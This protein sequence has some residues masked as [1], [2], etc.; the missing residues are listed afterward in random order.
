MK[1]AR[2]AS[3]LALLT[4]GCSP[5]PATAADSTGGAFTLSGLASSICR[6]GSAEGAAKRLAGVGAPA[7]RCGSATNG[8]LAP[9]IDA[10][11]KSDCSVGGGSTVAVCQYD[12]AQPG[13][14]KWVPAIGSG[15]GDQIRVNGA[16][17]TDPTLNDSAQIA[18]SASSNTITAAIAADS[19]ALGTHTSGAFVGGATSGGGLALTGSEP[20]TLGLL[21]CSSGQVLKHNGSAWACSADSGGDSF[22][23]FAASSGTNP[24]A[25]GSADTLQILA[26]TGVTV[27]GDAAADSL[28]IASTLGTTV[29]PTEMAASDFGPFSCNGTTCSIDAAAV[30]D[31]AVASGVDAAKLANGTVSNAEF[32]RLD[33][34]SSAIQS[35]LDAKVPLAGGT[36]S[37]QLNMGSQKITGL[38]PGSAAT[39]AVRYDQ[40]IDG[41]SVVMRDGSQAFTAAQSMGGNRITSLGSGTALTD[42]AS[43]REAA[44]CVGNAACVRVADDNG[45]AD[46][47]AELQAA[48]NALLWPSGT[49]TTAT[50]VVL[51]APP[52]RTY[53]ISSRI[54]ICGDT[55]PP[56]G[57]TAPDCTGTQQLPR[58]R[59]AG[60][61]SSAVLKCEL[62]ALSNVVQNMTPCIQIGD[63][64]ADTSF[65]NKVPLAFDTPLAIEMATTSDFANTLMGIWC[66]GC[67]ED[68]KVRVPDTK[69]SSFPGP[70]A[71]VAGGGLRTTL[72]VEKNSGS[73]ATVIFDG[74]QQGS[75]ASVRGSIYGLFIGSTVSTALATWGPADGCDYNG[76]TLSCADFHLLPET[77]VA[78]TSFS[79]EVADTEGAVIEGVMKGGTGTS[80]PTIDVRTG[81]GANSIRSLAIRATCILNAGSSNSC[82]RLGGDTAPGWTPRVAFD[83]HVESYISVNEPDKGGIGCNYNSANYAEIVLGPSASMRNTAGGYSYLLN[84]VNLYAP[85]QE[86]CNYS[87]PD[88]DTV[89]VRVA[90]QTLGASPPYCADLVDG[91]WRACSDE[92]TRL[93]RRD[94][95]ASWMQRAEVTLHGAAGSGTA[96]NVRVMKNGTDPAGNENNYFP[97]GFSYLVGSDELD[98][99]G[100]A[101]AHNVA[102]GA[103]ASDYWQIQVDDDYAT[104]GGEE[105]CLTT[106]A[107]GY[108]TASGTTTSLVDGTKAWTTNEHVG[109]RIVFDGGRGAYNIRTITA[110]TATSVTWSGALA[111]APYYVD[112][113]QRTRY[114]IVPSSGA[115]AC[116]SESLPEMTAELRAFRVSQ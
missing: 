78:L 43:M 101:V 58:I 96:C 65:A 116:A 47:T 97:Q 7:G 98:A 45:N 28:T 16:E 20:G 36:M 37:G 8:A 3:I 23:T 52:A 107:S 95:A 12:A 22:S 44:S 32:Q 34:V 55:S 85:H 14:N 53:T 106:H 59:F 38:A 49:L 113:S 94:W 109:R 75:S 90:A 18:F 17:Q 39:D 108:A 104:S 50:E 62:A 84:S 77:N 26:G 11:S 68:L 71:V 51:V 115:C 102:D 69:A 46:L 87:A 72:V 54:V 1:L 15:S 74:E 27:T 110:N 91:T 73:L 42:A 66:N 25:D 89:R 67:T 100:E 9:V 10:I 29:G 99:D 21:A 56:S 81:L 4:R 93:R 35:Q 5:E 2:V 40:M 105:A 82:V 13:A 114:R 61:W 103:V 41:A 92:R 63:A 79:V 57:S 33:G 48:L 86:P 70:A 6:I 60:A 76:L 88:T 31:S 19:V 64:W 111:Q 83:G 112:N 30:G 24:V 80:K